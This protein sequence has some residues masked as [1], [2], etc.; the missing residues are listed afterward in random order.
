MEP[1]IDPTEKFT[2]IAEKMAAKQLEVFRR[3][4]GCDPHPD[5][6][7]EFAGSAWEKTWASLQR[8]GAEAADYDICYECWHTVFFVGVRT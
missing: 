7:N 4:F 5:M 6:E 2:D 8:C 1:M 3:D